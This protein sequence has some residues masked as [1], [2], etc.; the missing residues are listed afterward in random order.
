MER[1]EWSGAGSVRAR[2]DL[3]RYVARHAGSPFSGGVMRAEQDG[4]LLVADGVIVYREPSRPFACAT[5]IGRAGLHRAG[6]RRAVPR[7]RADSTGFRPADGP[8]RR[9]FGLG[10][11]ARK[12][13]LDPGAP[14][15]LFCSWVRVP[16]MGGLVAWGT[17]R[18]GATTAREPVPERAQ[19]P[20]TPPA[21]GVVNTTRR[22]NVTPTGDYAVEEFTISIPAEKLQDLDRRLRNTRFPQA[23]ANDDWRYGARSRHHRKE[24]VARAVGSTAFL[25]THAM[26][27]C[28]S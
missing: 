3:P 8:T 26:P 25:T 28:A 24:G 10:A 20:G 13:A 14:A 21:L 1:E 18:Q 7:G 15:S 22:L 23:F 17:A 27:H 4:R 12:R 5:P 2:D 19:G 11:S 16:P 9:S 6:R